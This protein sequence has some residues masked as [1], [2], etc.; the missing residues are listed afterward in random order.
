M[1]VCC[2]FRVFGCAIAMTSV[3]NMLIPGACKIHFVAV[4]VVRILQGLVEVRI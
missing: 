1:R 4:M 2:V 3:L